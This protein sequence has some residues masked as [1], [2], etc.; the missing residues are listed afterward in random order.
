MLMVPG[1]SCLCPPSPG[2]G[3]DV[4]TLGSGLLY[5][6]TTKAYKDNNLN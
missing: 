5:G 3:L 6:S 2:S 4:L 1:G